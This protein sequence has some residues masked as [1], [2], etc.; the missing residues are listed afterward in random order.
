MKGWGDSQRARRLACGDELPRNAEVQVPTTLGYGVRSRT[1][2][3]VDN[4]TQRRYPEIRNIWTEA[5]C[6]VLEHRRCRDVHRSGPFKAA[7]R[8]DSPRRR[9]STKG[10]GNALIQYKHRIT[11]DRTMKGYVHVNVTVIAPKRHS[12]QCIIDLPERHHAMPKQSRKP[13]TNQLL[14]NNSLPLST[15]EFSS[16]PPS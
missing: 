16:A 1:A 9:T 6:C 8:Q 4:D 11:L 2:S 13:N 14:M 7:S 12:H 10:R 3:Y 5:R 15:G